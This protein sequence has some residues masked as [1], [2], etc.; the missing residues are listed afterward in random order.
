MVLKA[1]ERGYEQIRIELDG[2]NR[3]VAV[4]YPL[5][6]FFGLTF[7]WQSEA[8]FLT[9]IIWSGME[10]EVEIKRVMRAAFGP[11][12]LFISPSAEGPRRDGSSLKTL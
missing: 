9:N 5:I 7:R 1:F 4:A 12:T 6:E 2:L 3:S 10:R 11:L 8:V